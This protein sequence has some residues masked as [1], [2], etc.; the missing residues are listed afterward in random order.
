MTLR[1]KLFIAQ[2]VAIAVAFGVNLL[3]IWLQDDRW[4]NTAIL[5]WAVSLVSGLLLLMAWE[6]LERHH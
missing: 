4:A 2:L 6:E 3:A 5:V 1:T